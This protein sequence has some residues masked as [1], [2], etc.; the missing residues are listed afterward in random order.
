MGQLPG[1]GKAPIMRDSGDHHGVKNKLIRRRTVP[2]KPNDDAMMSNLKPPP[3]ARIFLCQSAAALL[4]GLLVLIPGWVSLSVSVLVGG[5]ISVVS[6][7]YF[8]IKAFSQVGAR[9]TPRIVTNMFVGE[10]VKLVLIGTGFALA[11]VFMETVSVPGLFAGFMLVHVTGILAA[12]NLP[13]TGSSNASQ[14]FR[15]QA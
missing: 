5:T 10:A 8:A 3:I 14:R 2:E 11:L 9:A 15:S 4:L 12:I 13:Y 7:G 1:I 6:N